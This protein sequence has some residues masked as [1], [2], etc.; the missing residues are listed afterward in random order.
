MFDLIGGLPLHPL[1]V[2]AVVVLIPLVV[3]GTI[4][5]VVHPAWRERWIVPILIAL[6]LAGACLPIA[7]QSGEALQGR[8]GDPGYNHQ[9]LGDLLLFISFLLWVVLVWWWRLM[10][11]ARKAAPNPAAPRRPLARVVAGLALV[12]AVATGVQVYLVGDSGARAAWTQRI[13]GTSPTSHP[14][15]E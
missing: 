3:L 5:I 15:H 10:V 12:L 6:T 13:A 7:T 8:V 9:E 14:E 1:V 11:R 2:H 4:A